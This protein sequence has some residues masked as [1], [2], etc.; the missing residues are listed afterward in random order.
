MTYFFLH[1]HFFFYILIVYTLYLTHTIVSIY[2]Y[3]LYMWNHKVWWQWNTRNAI[4]KLW[5]TL[6]AEIWR[7][8]ESFMA[9][10][11]TLKERYYYRFQFFNKTCLRLRKCVCVCVQRLI[12]C[13]SSLSTFN[14]SFS[15]ILISHS[16]TV[17]TFNI[18]WL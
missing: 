2:I 16:I 11:T 15:I 7:F 4:E 9:N 18:L 14:S 13:F 6:C 8:I 1:F 10:N 3:T 5:I 17:K 12:D